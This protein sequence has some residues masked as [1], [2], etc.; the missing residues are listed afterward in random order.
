MG[1]MRSGELGFAGYFGFGGVAG[2]TQMFGAFCVGVL[3][4]A[5]ADRLIEG[6]VAG[7]L[8]RGASVSLELTKDPLFSVSS[9]SGLPQLPTRENNTLATSTGRL[10]A[11][12]SDARPNDFRF[13]L[14][15][16]DIFGFDPDG[17]LWEVATVASEPTMT[18]PL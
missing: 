4:S 6:G 11:I 5:L 3:A 17:E 1:D 18:L 8:V 10:E 12:S 7:T 13:L 14:D 2:V 9:L 16:L 15:F